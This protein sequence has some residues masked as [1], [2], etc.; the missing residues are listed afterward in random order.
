M[1]T[2]IEN[3]NY[4]DS[5]RKYSSTFVKIILSN[6]KIETVKDFVKKVIQAKANENHHV[7]DS[8]MEEKRWTTGFLGEAAVEKFIDTEFIDF[9]VGSSNKYHVSD[10]K[11]IGYDCGVKTVEK[12]KFPVI[13]RKSYKPE[14]IVV[15]QSD[16]V[17]YI[18]GLA[19]VNILNKY[20]SL[21][22]I[23]SPSLRKRGTK[24][25]FYGF[26]KLIKPNNIKKHLIETRK[27][28]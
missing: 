22:L 9:S 24:T 3:I 16:K 19:T 23:L 17:F 25:G 11:K 4:N 7:V 5:V 6:T 12:E 13:F 26:H 18:C 15:K 10:L 21:D 14:I 28:Q 20:Q 8:G 27:I 1:E 2:N